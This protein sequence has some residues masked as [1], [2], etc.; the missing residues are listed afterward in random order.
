M[1]VRAVTRNVRM[2]AGKGRP[3]AREIQGMPVS[4]ALQVVDFSPRK[5]AFHLSNTLKS[6]L[7]NA[8][9]KAGVDVDTLTVKRAVFD[10]GARLRRFWP[11][12]RGS[13]SPILRRLCHVTVVLSDENVRGKRGKQ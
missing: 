9:G 8:R 12:A 2:S 1:E 13:A 10:E 4:R 7:A 6:A 3:I 11:R 5:A